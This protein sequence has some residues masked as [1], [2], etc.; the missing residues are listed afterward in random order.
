MIEIGK[1]CVKLAGRDAGKECLIVDI[2]DK[3]KQFV[4]IDGNTR[5]RKCNTNHLEILPQK[6]DIKKGA[7]HEEVVKA[8]ASLGVK[9]L[10]KAPPREKKAEAKPKEAPK[11]TKKPLLR[12]PGK[13]K[14]AQ[15]KTAKEE[16]KPKKE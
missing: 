4:L 3:N 13:K 6:A 5:R 12:L 1:L 9:V 14:T 8:L 7:S 2:L 15:K 10:P 16:G 11:K